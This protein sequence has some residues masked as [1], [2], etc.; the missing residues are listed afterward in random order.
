MISDQVFT[1]ERIKQLTQNESNQ[2]DPGNSNIHEP[3][4]VELP[5]VRGSLKI[6]VEEKKD[7]GMFFFL[8]NLFPKLLIKDLNTA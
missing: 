1:M 2:K 6:F 3:P 7:H 5:T 8:N 4:A